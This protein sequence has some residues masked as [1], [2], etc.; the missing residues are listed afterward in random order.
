MYLDFKARPFSCLSEV[1]G[2]ACFYVCKSSYI[3]K[4][5]ATVLVLIGYVCKYQF[6]LLMAVT[7]KNSPLLA[8]TYQN[9]TI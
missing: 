5:A 1:L 2:E 7:A 6:D 4:S 8:I 9:S 3:Y